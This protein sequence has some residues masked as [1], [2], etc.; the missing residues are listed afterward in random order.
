MSRPQLLKRLVTATVLF[1]LCSALFI[2]TNTRARAASTLTSTTSSKISP[3]LQQLLLS[4]YGD[5]RVKVIVQS[6]STSTSLLGGLLNTVGGL[7]V[8]VLSNV[9]LRIVDVQVNSVPVL[10]TDPSV[11]YISLDA[12]V[13]SSGHITNTTGTQQVRAQ[14]SLLGLDNTLDGSGVTIAILDS[15][16]DSTHKSFATTGK[17]KFSKD[18]TGENRTDDPWG[19]GTHVAAIAAGD[20]TPTSGAYEGLAPGANLVNLRVLDSNG[21]GRVSNVLAALDWL[22]ANKGN[23]GVRGVN[24]SLGTPAISSDKDH[25]LCNAVRK[26]VDSGVVVVAAAGNNGKDANGQKIYGA[27]HCPGNEPSAITVGA[28]NSFGTDARNEDSVTSYSSRGP[29]R[30]YSVDSYGLLHYDNLI[31]PDLV[32]PGNK[33][34]AAEAVS[35]N[36]LKKYP[37][38]ETNKYSTT[39]M[40]LMYLSGTSMSTP[41][42]SGAAA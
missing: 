27:I 22:I 37:D 16:I 10:A 41:M 11:S 42:V 20:G 24:M 7:V 17:I 3:D 25:A 40:K 13:G 8:S 31:K 30:S 33:I 5:T 32:A 18:F 38:L 14:K 2:S 29:T 6:T 34:I 35:N 26:L 19:H 36:L 9:N 1:S 21:M 12:Q 28:S 4:G 23:Y 39:N 15:G